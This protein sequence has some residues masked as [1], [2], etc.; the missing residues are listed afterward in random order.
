MISV[1]NNERFE[2]IQCEL[3]CFKVAVFIHY[4]ESVTVAGIKNLTRG[5]IVRTAV[6]VTSELFQAAYTVILH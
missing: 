2:G 3:A 1:S 4:D 6:C 5:R